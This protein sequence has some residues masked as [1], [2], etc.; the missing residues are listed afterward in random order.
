MSKK[1]TVFII[2]DDRVL[3][4]TVSTVEEGTNTYNIAIQT[5]VEALTWH[6]NPSVSGIIPQQLAIQKA[7]PETAKP[8]NLEDMKKLI[9]KDFGSKPSPAKE[10]NIQTI[11]PISMKEVLR[12]SSNNSN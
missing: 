10:F 1:I 4:H 11:P 3:H 9:A 5:I 6:K 8:V 7:M 2:E 12:G